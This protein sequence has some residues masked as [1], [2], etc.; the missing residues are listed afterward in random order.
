MLGL[1]MRRYSYC[2]IIPTGISRVPSHTFGR[3]TRLIRPADFV[4]LAIFAVL[5]VTALEYPYRNRENEI[6]GPYEF[7]PLIA[8]GAAQMLEPK[9]PRIPS[10]RSRVFWIV[11]KVV[12]SFLL[13]G[14][15]GAVVS[16]YWPVLLLPVV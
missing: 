15:T 6:Q 9:I 3:W 8:L 11:A 5:V 13:I 4:W 16:N 2:G 10:R 7:V 14:F 12:L 1:A